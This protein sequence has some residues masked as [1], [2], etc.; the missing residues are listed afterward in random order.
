MLAPPEDMLVPIWSNCAVIWSCGVQISLGS[1]HLPRVNGPIAPDMPFAIG[2][3]VSVHVAPKYLAWS[4]E[5]API[6]RETWLQIDV[7]W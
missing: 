4:R 5:T 2:A 7:D 6:H 1:L 3:T